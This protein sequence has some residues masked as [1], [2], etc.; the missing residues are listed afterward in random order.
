[1]ALSELEMTAAKALL[2]NGFDPCY[3]GHL[4]WVSSGGANCGCH[5]TAACSVPV[6]HC[7]VCGDSDYGDNEEADE[8]RK[9]CHEL[10]GHYL[11]EEDEED[12]ETDPAEPNAHDAEH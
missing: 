7:T 6:Y 4:D 11:D 3:Q 2:E 1:M 9:R 12:R 10:F 8:Q 5:P